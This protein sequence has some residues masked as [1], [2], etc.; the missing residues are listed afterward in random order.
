MQ[1]DQSDVLAV[2]EGRPS[3]F[4]ASR[5]SASELFEAA[6]RPRVRALWYVVAVTAAIVGAIITTWVFRTGGTYYPFI[7]GFVMVFALLG[8]FGPSVIASLGSLGLAH[9][10]PPAGAMLP[11]SRAELVRLAANV[12]LLLIAS[13]LAGLFRRSRLMAH[14][15]QA[16]L[17][18]AS[19]SVRELLD[20]STEALVL[21]D[22]AYRITYV[23]AC[24][25]AMFG[26]AAKDVIGRSVETIITAESL[27]QRPIDVSAVRTGFTLRTERTARRADGTIIHIDIASR[28]LSGGRL[29]VSV[30]D[31]TE[32]RREAE[33]QRAER[34]LLDGILAT[35][36]AGVLV[37]SPSG[38]II[39]ANRRAESVLRL[40]RAVDGTRRYERPLWKQAALHGGDWPREAQPFRQVADTGMPVFDVRM[41]IV[42]PD[43]SRTAL[44]VNGAPL[45][46]ANGQLQG[47][48]L[49]VNDIT[50]ALDAERA[51]RERDRQLEQITDAMPGIVYQ[52]VIDAEGRDRFVFVSRFSEKLLGRTASQL[53]DSVESAWS[54]VHP[55]DIEPSKRSLMQSFHSM[56]TW[57]H[58]LRIQ[59]VHSSGHWR[60]VSGHAVP[61]PGPEPGSVLWNGIFIDITDRRTLEDDL[62]QAQRI[63]SVGRLAGG[64]AHDFNNLLTVILGQAELLLLDAPVGSAQAEGIQQ[65]RAAAE[66]GSALTRQL[67]G[68]ARKQVV[69][70]RVVDVNALVERVKPLVGRLIGETI[71]LKLVLMEAPPR[72][73]VDP[74]QLDQVLVNLVVNARDAMP[75]GGHLEISTRMIDPI[76]YHRSEHGPHVSG[77]L[78]EIAVRD[79]GSGMSEEI[80]E[81]AF[82]PFFTTKEHGKGTGLGLAT[83]YGI[84][85]QA[86]GT[87]LLESVPGQGSVVRVLLPVTDAAVVSRASDVA[88]AASGGRETVLVVDD[89]ELVRGVT[90]AALRRQGYRVLE[91]DGGAAALLRARSETAPIHALVTDVVM[92]HMTGPELS[93]QLLR[94]R[95]GLRVLYLSG[96]AEGTIAHH[97]VLD[98]GIALL[99]KPYDIHELASRVRALLDA[100]T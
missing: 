11:D 47:V 70:P 55:D 80:R 68:F 59:D 49:A 44:S 43:T 92:P 62:R 87:M 2:P 8:G 10:L 77:A 50:E 74:A 28:F 83:S 15:R 36:V 81:R 75:H 71:A 18:R 35:S 51:L 98:D 46:D 73:R 3:I 84:V 97:G 69:A 17:E 79:S 40:A 66:S 26:Y 100:T 56:T 22:D 88:P 4:G 1:R 95:P 78:V 9:L 24:A 89:D 5:S 91:S 96:Y 23:N 90:A 13:L 33:R 27:A 65:L 54:L 82:E 85:S 39:F 52:Y 57:N 14:Q 64:I 21:T 60:W 93:A 31:T 32:P 53:L 42:W 58:E 30:R 94:E 37:V 16:Q 7:S 61:Q 76:A 6:G 19:A 63:E 67:L 25:E 99:Q 20:G 45:R 38:E 86:G 41:A 48:V 72:V 12:V 29:L 34:D